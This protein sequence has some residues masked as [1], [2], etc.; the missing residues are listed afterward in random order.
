MLIGDG[1]ITNHP[2]YKLSHSKNQMEY[3]EWKIKLLEQY[4]FNHGGLKTYV[5]KSG[6]NEGSDVIYVRVKT[7]LTV[8]SIRYSNMVYG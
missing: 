6:Y 8:K 1:T 4:G 3:L 5:S 2:D 7:N